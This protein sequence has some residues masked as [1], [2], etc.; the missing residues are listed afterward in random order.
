MTTANFFTELALI[1]W[2]NGPFEF[3]NNER[4]DDC[5]AMIYIIE[6]S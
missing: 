5:Y 3:G 6:E 1:T 4:R 2:G